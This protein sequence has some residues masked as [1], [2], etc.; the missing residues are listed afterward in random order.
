MQDYDI[1][2]DDIA[3]AVPWF[4]SL[5]THVPVVGQVHHVHQEVLK[6]ELSPWL[7]HAVALGEKSLKFFYNNMIV[8][9]DSTKHDLINML[10]FDED[11]IKVII[12]GVD[13]KYTP[14]KKSNEPTL[15]YVGRIKRYKRIDHIL[16]AF[17]YVKRKIPSAR[18]FIVGTGDDLNHLL[19]IRK[20]YNLHDCVFTG[21]V[22]EREKIKLMATAWLILNT[23]LIEG[24]GMTIT[25]AGACGT[26]C[27]A[28]NVPGMRDSVQNGV[29]G[30]LT[31]NGDIRSLAEKII[32]I[33]EENN[34]RKNLSDNALHFAKQLDWDQSANN[35]SRLLQGLV[36]DK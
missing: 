21:R 18:L 12:N 32:T 2:I 25:E 19:R 15:I 24:W 5:Y 11:R 26:P 23:S 17:S 10:G 35:F 8:V 6:Y 36:D 27:A 16:A 4:S 28:Y 31:Q 7:A 29:T 1:V 13:A 20:K 22:S 14:M 3:H 34:L 9:S 30:L 33:L